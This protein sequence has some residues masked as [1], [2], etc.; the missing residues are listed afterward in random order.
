MREMLLETLHDVQWQAMSGGN[1]SVWVSWRHA[2][3]DTSVAA[4]CQCDNLPWSKLI[5]VDS[6]IC[7]LSLNAQL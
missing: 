6:S 3:C 7:L 5:P 2:S 1:D 4:C